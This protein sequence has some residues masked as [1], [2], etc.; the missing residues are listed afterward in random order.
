LVRPIERRKLARR[1]VGLQPLPPSTTI[2]R[3]GTRTA[4][5]TG[6]RTLGIGSALIASIVLVLAAWLAGRAMGFNVSLVGSL[7]LTILLTVVMN[8]ALGAWSRRA[9]RY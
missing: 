7:G 3:D 1:Y 5:S 9:R 2:E 4:R 6:M 8:L